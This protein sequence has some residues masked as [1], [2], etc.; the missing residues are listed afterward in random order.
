MTNKKTLAG[1]F[2]PGLLCF[3]AVLLLAVRFPGPCL[4]CA[5]CFALLPLPRGL[6]LLSRWCASRLAVRVPWWWAAFPGSRPR[7]L[8][9]LRS[10]AW[11]ASRRFLR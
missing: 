2:V 1:W 7:G 4:S 8:A 3:V 6:A 5:L 11:S 9:L 10:A